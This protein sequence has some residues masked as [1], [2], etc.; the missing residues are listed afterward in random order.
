MIIHFLLYIF[1][2]QEKE[3]FNLIIELILSEKL[4]FID[5]NM[6]VYKLVPFMDYTTSVSLLLFI[7]QL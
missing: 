1:G 4:C 2:F 5:K 6:N 3:N 7:F